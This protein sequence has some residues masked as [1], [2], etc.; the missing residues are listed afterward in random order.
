MSLVTMASILRN[1]M[2]GNYA[3][4]AFDALEKDSVDAI[5][6]AAEAVD[7]PVILMVPEAGLPLINMEQFFQYMVEAAKRARIPV[8]LELDHGKCYETIVKAIHYGFTGVMID[9]SELSYE[10]NAA[11]TR[12]VVEVAHA[13]GVSVEAEIGHV[14]GGEGNMEEGSEVDV[15]MYTDPDSARHFAMD[16]QVDALAIAFGTV[17]GIYKGTPKLDLGRLSEIRRQVSIPLVMH[18]GSGVSDEEFQKAVAAGINKVNFFTEISMSAAV[19]A[20]EF[21]K[22]RNYRLHYAEMVFAAQKKIEEI[23]GHYLELLK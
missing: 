16:T 15:S 6:K 20:A 12:R 14:A 10:D 13:A 3:V 5:I 9:G 22:E 2:Q 23:T 4:P 17:H 8:A 19:R 21:C 11:L 1:A 18:G 7:R